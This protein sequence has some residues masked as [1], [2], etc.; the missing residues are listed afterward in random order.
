MEITSETSKIL[1]EEHQNILKVIN[2]LSSECNNL[3]AGKEINKDFLAK[4][5]DFIRNYA[6]K[7]HHAKEEDILFKEFCKVAE[8]GEVHCNP[9]EQMLHEHELGRGFVRELEEGVREN[10]REKVIKGIRGYTSLLPDHIFKE[11]NILYPMADEVLD[12]RIKQEMLRK[13]EQ[14]NKEKSKD[15]E[16]YL[17]FVRSLS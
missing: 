16:K 5:I 15:K 1:V 6:D 14:V 12:S 9:V 10:D 8:K 7:F 4:A 2:V 3:G 13:F 17:A 11:D